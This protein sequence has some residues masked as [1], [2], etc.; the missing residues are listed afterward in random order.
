[1][2]RGRVHARR[3][4]P[5]GMRTSATRAHLV[6]LGGGESRVAA[7]VMHG[8][9]KELIVL[10]PTEPVVV[11]F[12]QHESHTYTWITNSPTNRERHA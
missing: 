1:M 6:P 3:E 7:L 4:A 11:K 2:D 12:C 10:L 5:L 8:F 9:I